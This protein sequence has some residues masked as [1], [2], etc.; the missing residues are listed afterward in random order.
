[1]AELTEAAVELLE[2]NRMV[3]AI[4]V[5]RSLLE[6]VALLYWLYKQLQLAIA[7]GSSTKAKLF[8]QK[9]LLGSR[10]E[11]SPVQPHNVLDAIDAVSKDIG[12]FRKTYEELCEVA[13]PNMFGCLG[14]YGKWNKEKV[15]CELSSQRIPPFIG[16][17]PL[18]LSLELFIYFYDNMIALLQGFA[19][20]CEAEL[21]IEPNTIQAP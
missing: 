10:A 2:N 11:S 19:R 8:L 4:T 17:S 12:L 16:L 21:P 14:A 6:T 7:E 9:A 13:H 18:V 15:W 20:I 3:A 1:V 5:I